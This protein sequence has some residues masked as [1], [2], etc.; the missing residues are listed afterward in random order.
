MQQ[1][2]FFGL[3]CNILSFCAALSQSNLLQNKGQCRAMT[4]VQW[5]HCIRAQSFRGHVEPEDLIDF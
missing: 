3:L 4:M 5:M 1:I 2:L